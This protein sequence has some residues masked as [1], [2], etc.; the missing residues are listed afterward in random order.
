MATLS[1][2]GGALVGAGLM[3]FLLV[4]AIATMLFWG[5]E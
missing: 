4:I 1:F 3:L 2:I 5:D